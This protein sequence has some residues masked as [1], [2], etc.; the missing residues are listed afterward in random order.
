LPLMARRPR[1]PR[2]FTMLTPKVT[3]LSTLPS[4]HG[5]GGQ[6]GAVAAAPSASRR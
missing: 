5:S 6:S 1:E 4:A 2:F 3:C